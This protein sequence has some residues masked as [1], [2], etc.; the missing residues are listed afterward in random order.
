MVDEKYIFQ[1][2]GIKSQFQKRQLLQGIRLLGGKYIGGS[3]SIC[4]SITSF[5][6]LYNGSSDQVSCKKKKK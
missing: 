3:V 4:T 2:S 5:L 1:M 6:T